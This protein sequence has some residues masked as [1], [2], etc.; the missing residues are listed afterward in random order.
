MA[1]S[2]SAWACT[3]GIQSG[4]R[5][6][7]LTCNEQVRNEV[8]PR[9]AKHG[10]Q[11][12][13]QTQNNRAISTRLLVRSRMQLVREIVFPLG[14]NLC[15][16]SSLGIVT[17]GEVILPNS[18][19]PHGGLNPDGPRTADLDAFRAGLGLESK[20]AVTDVAGIGPESRVEWQ[21]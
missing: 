21:E 19:F 4:A 12:S 11:F 2:L 15:L 1:L 20:L 13:Q 17:P 3:K 7:I 14:G 8:V 18:G 9:R 5:Y 6:P 16:K 10:S